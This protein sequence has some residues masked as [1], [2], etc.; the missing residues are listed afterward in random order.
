MRKLKHAVALVALAAIFFSAWGLVRKR[1]RLI[2]AMEAHEKQQWHHS[3]LAGR[4]NPP[5]RLVGSDETTT[6][7]TAPLG[8]GANSKY[9]LLHSPSGLRAFPVT[10][11]P[12][13]A[14]KRA[15][16]WYHY[17]LKEKY[18]RATQRPWASVTPDPPPPG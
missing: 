5:F 12:P 3:T 11:P 14:R 2:R 10:L 9:D 6:L 15:L 16:S 1:N 7:A 18:R 4:L 13:D 8:T 17:Q